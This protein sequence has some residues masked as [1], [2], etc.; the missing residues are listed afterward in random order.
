[1][2]RTA[3]ALAAGILLFLASSCGGS[4][5]PAP[6]PPA[7]ERETSPAPEESPAELDES[8]PAPEEPVVDQAAIM[9]ALCDRSYTLYE[10]PSPIFGANLFTQLNLYLPATA[11]EVFTFAPGIG[12]G[13]I[14]KL[15]RMDCRASTAVGWRPV[16]EDHVEPAIPDR[17]RRKI[18]GSGFYAPVW[19]LIDSPLGLGWIGPSLSYTGLLPGQPMS[20]L[21]A[22]LSLVPLEEPDTGGG[23]ADL[24]FSASGRFH[25]EG[26]ACI[27]GQF[28]SDRWFVSVRN[29]G[30]GVSPRVFDTSIG[31]RRWPVTWARGLEPGEA[32]VFALSPPQLRFEIDPDD[33]I[34][35]SDE[36][37]NSFV[38][39]ASPPLACVSQ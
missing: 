1:M 19:F 21:L 17:L 11:Y 25:E 27:P 15:S 16:V 18:I 6:S 14:G 31:G 30:N 10:L 9:R 26:Q 33:R 5:E 2:S 13:E 22:G 38:V 36:G 3:T 39:P 29:A 37:N 23:L 34:E 12:F 32:V 28:I 20:D 7:E 35:E 4:E 8:P 24:T